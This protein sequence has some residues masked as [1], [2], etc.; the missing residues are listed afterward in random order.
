LPPHSAAAIQGETI[1][2][3]L[4]VRAR[5]DSK[6]GLQ[7]FAR[8]HRSEGRI[9][10][11]LTN[12]SSVRINQ[13][14]GKVWK[15]L[16]EFQLPQP[17]VAGDDYLME[18]RVV[19]SQI[20]ARFNERTLGETHHDSHPSGL[21]GVSSYAADPVAIKA[22]HF[23]PLD[24]QGT[25]PGSQASHLTPT[26]SGGTPDFLS[27]TKD[28]PFVNGLGMKFVPV[29][30]T[31]GPTG[32][33]RILFSIWETRVQDYEAFVQETK[34]KWTP[35]GGASVPTHPAVN[36]S[37]DD[38]QAFCAWLTERER[39]AGKLSATERYR[40][41]SDHEWSCAVGIG[42]REDAAILPEEKS[43]KLPNTFPWGTQWPPPEG[44]GNFCDERAKAE[45]V[46]DDTGYLDGYADGYAMLA[47][48]GSFPANA[49]GLF[50]LAGNVSEWCEDFAGKARSDR[51]CRS[52]AWLSAIQTHL[53]S[54]KRHNHP[55][56]HASFSI[57]FRVV[58]APAH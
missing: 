47:P 27:A 35:W 12:S 17:L 58:L 53:L 29:P 7:L 20:I 18:L 21:M 5:W 6:V 14:D 15:T 57:G 33:Q 37:W 4:R 11:A 19:G 43:Q 36:A 9:E 3:A 48:V 28:A 51:V 56:S 22:L 52:S 25:A 32:G 2:G 38:A 1:D 46:R 30:I 13:N 50:D 42:D 34:H 44:V 8:E 24:A 39:K 45:H 26:P 41:P 16:R 49:V 55:P 23:L 31:G 40:L 54:S 10:M